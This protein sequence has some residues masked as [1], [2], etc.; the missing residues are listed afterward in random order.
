MC[1]VSHSLPYVTH[2]RMGVVVDVSRP[3]RAFLPSMEGP[4]LMVLAGTTLPLGMSELHRMAS[5]GSLGGVRHALE[6]TG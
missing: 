5:K 2:Q 3:E 1:G 4:V 6:K